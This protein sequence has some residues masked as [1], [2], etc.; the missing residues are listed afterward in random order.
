MSLRDAFLR[1]LSTLSGEEC[2]GVVCG[3]G[4]G[5]VLGLNIGARTPKQKPVNNP[6]LSELVR[7]YDCAYS[8]LIW[9]PW[10]IDSE[11]KVIAGSHMPNAND[12]PMV[13]GSQSICQQRITGV[14]YSSPA[15]DLRLN[16]ENR[17]SL[18][19]HCSA[20]GKNYEVCYSF[21][22]PLGHYSVDLDGNLS[23]EG[24]E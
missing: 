8:M 16:F 9:C 19:I 23:F 24:R 21:G 2:W 17:Y 12:G 6:H 18:V 20:I 22:T 13:V 3:E 11:S 7:R 1:D 4:S 14:T 5:S 10:R 15:F